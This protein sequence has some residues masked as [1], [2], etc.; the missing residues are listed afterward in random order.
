[1]IAGRFPEHFLWGTAT[2]SH[3]VE[4]GNH[5]NDWWAWE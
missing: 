4:G 3:Q 5:G 2:A 1:M